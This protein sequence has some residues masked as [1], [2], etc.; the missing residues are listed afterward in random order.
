MANQIRAT[1]AVPEAPLTSAT[2]TLPT[3]YNLYGSPS[4]RQYFHAHR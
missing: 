4:Y 2:Q 1:Q 3:L